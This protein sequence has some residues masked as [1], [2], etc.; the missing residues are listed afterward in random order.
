MPVQRLVVTCSCLLPL[1][2]AGP[3]AAQQQGGP[4]NPSVYDPL[5]GMDPDGRIPKPEIPQDVP[6]PERWRYTPEAR[7]KPGNVFERFLVSSF[8]SPIVFREEDIGFGGGVA[9]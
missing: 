4:P 5:R 3:L 1:A 9:S 7:M 6:H 2:F 8:I